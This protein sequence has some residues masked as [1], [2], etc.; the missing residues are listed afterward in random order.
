VSPRVP[1][2]RELLAAGVGGLVSTLLARA[3]LATGE[4][5]IPKVL[6]SFAVATLDDQPVCDAAWIQEQVD[7]MEGLFG[8]LGVHPESVAVRSMSS[9]FA[10]L[11][12]RSD[13]DALLAEARDGVVNVFIVGTLRDVDDPRLLRRGVHWRHRATPSRRYVILAVEATPSVLA[14]EMGHYCGLGHSTTK[15]NLMSY[16]RTGG[17]VF[18]D[19]AQGRVIQAAARQAFASGELQPRH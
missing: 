11:E 2:R 13:R 7:V 12:S 9:T 1:S 17:D 15:D 5:P 6:L 4:G 16:D 8:P 14:H 3:A 10:H 19:A 18:L